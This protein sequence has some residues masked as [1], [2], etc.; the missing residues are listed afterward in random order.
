MDSGV[1]KGAKWSPRL[2]ITICFSGGGGEGIMPR[3]LV[4]LAA[5][6][7]MGETTRK[8]SWIMD[9][10]T[11]E[12]ISCCACLRDMKIHAVVQHVA[13]AINTKVQERER[14]N[15]MDNNIM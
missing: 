11:V 12:L 13:M 2:C 4:M 15:L 10:T 7:E 5:P 14:K 8:T 9:N 6:P 3:I 1:A